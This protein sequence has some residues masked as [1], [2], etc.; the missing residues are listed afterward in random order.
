MWFKPAR[1]DISPT[2]YK[3]FVFICP[4]IYMC[5]GA[6]S[7][8]PAE[9][10]HSR[11]STWCLIHQKGTAGYCVSLT[12]TFYGCWLLTMWGFKMRYFKSCLHYSY[13]GKLYLW[14]IEIYLMFSSCTPNGR[15]LPFKDELG[16]VISCLDDNWSWESWFTD[17]ISALLSEM[18]MCLDTEI[19][20]KSRTYII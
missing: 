13:L 15:L 12:Y 16:L 3:P 17:S 1:L 19:G 14:V 18:K 5:N 8:S 4:S 9:L 2:T 20:H 7:R 6:N 11:H 10:T